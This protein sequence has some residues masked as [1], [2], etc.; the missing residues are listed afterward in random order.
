MTVAEIMAAQAL[1][2]GDSNRLFAVGKYQVIPSTMKGAAAAMGLT[3]KE[4]F[5]PELQERTSP[6]T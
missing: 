5:T 4:Q 1:P 2:E 6:T 3:G